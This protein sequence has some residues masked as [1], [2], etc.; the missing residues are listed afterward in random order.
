MNKPTLDEIKKELENMGL[1]EKV[2]EVAKKIETGI[3]KLPFK[4]KV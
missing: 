4:P 1:A 3:E 2:D